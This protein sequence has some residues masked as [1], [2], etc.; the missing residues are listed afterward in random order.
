VEE[1]KGKNAVQCP[2]IVHEHHCMYVI[3]VYPIDVLLNTGV[4]FKVGIGQ[5]DLVT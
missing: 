3:P 1:G 5:S 2:S 4:Q